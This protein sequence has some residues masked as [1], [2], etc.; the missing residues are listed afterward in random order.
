VYRILKPG[1]IFVTQ[2]VGGKNNRELSKFLLENDLMDPNFNL[3]STQNDLLN[4][5]FNI[6]DGR[7]CFPLL[8]FYDVGALVYFAKIIEW[9]FPDFSVD[10][11]FER[12]CYLQ[13]KIE[14]IGYI[15]S[16]EHRFL[17]VGS[18]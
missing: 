5:G 4:A 8:K 7:E 11:C 12:L 14:E 2:Q 1:G 18:K 13:E 17:V 6:S 16:V 9:E 15:Q 10:K 3:Q